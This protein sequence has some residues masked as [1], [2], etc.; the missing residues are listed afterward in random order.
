[1]R[2]SITESIDYLMIVTI[3]W[4]SSAQREVTKKSNLCVF[5]SM[6]LRLMWISLFWKNDKMHQRAYVNVTWILSNTSQENLFKRPRL[7][8]N[9]FDNVTTSP[10]IRRHENGLLRSSY[11]RRKIYSKCIERSLALN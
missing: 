3:C 8:S 4:K 6:I 9:L 10:I 1:M 5:A 11:L 7:K 2:I